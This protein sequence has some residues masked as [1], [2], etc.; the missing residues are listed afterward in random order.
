M[1]KLR[2]L[3]YN[4]L[5]RVMAAMLVLLVLPYIG[6]ATDCSCTAQQQDSV[7]NQAAQ[8][9][10]VDCCH[11]ITSICLE[12]K[13]QPRCNWPDHKCAVPLE[14]CDRCLVPDKSCHKPLEC[15]MPCDSLCLEEVC[16]KPAV[17]VIPED[18]CTA[19]RAPCD[20]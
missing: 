16:H 11:L 17:V 12:V 15:Y 2:I 10:A 1:S 14:P 18:P 9:A 8:P 4:L 20:G 13:F 7:E 5:M 19:A 3:R 6:W